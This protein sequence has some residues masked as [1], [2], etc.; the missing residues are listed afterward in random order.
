MLDALAWGGHPL[1][2]Q[3]QAFP[4]GVASRL[5]Q[6]EV[7]GNTLLRWQQLVVGDVPSSR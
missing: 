3:L 2:E 1:H 6:L 4:H 5:E 7:D